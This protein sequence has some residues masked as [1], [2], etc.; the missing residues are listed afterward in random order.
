[1]EC[2]EIEL[3]AE[4]LSCYDAAAD[5]IKASLEKPQVGSSEQRQEQRNAEVAAV[6]GQ[7]EHAHL[8][9]AVLK[10]LKMG[11]IWWGQPREQTDC[12][13]ILLSMLSLWVG[14]VGFR[15]VSAHRPACRPLFIPGASG[16]CVRWCPCC[17]KRRAW[18]CAPWSRAIT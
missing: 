5:A 11:T 18:R 10:A 17:C 4:R 7:P 16:S 14:V 12:W 13:K 6:L 1:M 3:D 9:E 15:Q 8:L 2:S